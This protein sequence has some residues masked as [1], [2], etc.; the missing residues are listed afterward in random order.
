MTDT[1]DPVALRAELTLDEGRKYYPYTDS[2]GCLSIGIGRNLTGVGISAAEIDF[3]FA[4]DTAESCA[5]LDQKVQ[6]WRSLPPAQQRVMINL[7]FN[8]GWPKFAQFQKFLAAM[9]AGSWAG[10]ASELAD[11]LWYG[12]VGLRGPRMIAR[13]TTIIPPNGEPA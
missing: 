4:N 6:W 5:M 11:S 3:L 9:Q 2:R 10:A 7:C 1:F 8:L 13:L 12:Q